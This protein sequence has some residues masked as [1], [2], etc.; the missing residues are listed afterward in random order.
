L[1]SGR[2]IS[3]T[4]ASPSPSALIINEFLAVNQNG[5]TDEDGD[6]SDWIEIYNRSDSA[7]NLAGWSLTTDPN[8]PQQWP[9]PD[10]TLDSEDYLI[11]FASGK[12]RRIVQ[13]GASLHTNFK[14]S[15]KGEYL[16]LYNILE[17]RMMDVISPRFPN[18]F[19]DI[20]YGRYSDDL[21]FG[22]LANP[23]PGGANDG[24]LAWIGSLAPVA[25]S[26]ERGLFNS[27]FS[28]ELTTAT[29]EATIRYTTDGSEPTATT[30]TI[31]TEPI[32]VESTTLLRTAAFKPNYL[33]SEV[34]T[35]SYIFVEDAIPQP[36]TSPDSSSAVEDLLASLQ[37][38]DPSLSVSMNDETTAE[39]V[40]QEVL[41]ASLKSILSISL[42]MKPQHLDDFSAAALKQ[43]KES[44]RPASV[45]LMVPDDNETGFQV[46]AGVRLYGISEAGGSNRKLA[47]QLSFKRKYGPTKLEYPLFPD[48]SLTTFDTL[49][50]QPR[51]SSN[52]AY[53]H[54]EWLR[55][56]QMA[57]SGLGVHSIPVHLYL[58]GQYWGLYNLIERPDA[59]FM[60]AYIGGE[61]TDWFVASQSGPLSGNLDDQANTLTYLFTTLA[62]AP[63]LGSE[64][65]QPDYLDQVY[66]AAGSYLDPAL[67]SDYMI[68]NLYTQSLDWPDSN[69]YAAIRLQDLA[70]RGRILVGDERQTLSQTQPSL[71][72]NNPDDT[73]RDQ[74]VKA[75]FKTLMENPD[76]RV[77]FADRLYTHLFK[78]GALIDAN[79]QARWQRLNSKIDEAIV[80]E[81]VRWGNRSE[82]QLT[83]DEWR[84]TVES[85]LDKMEGQA[86][87]F[88]S[89][90]REAG[91]YP[92]LDP[93]VF[94]QD[95]G[96]VETGFTM[97][98]DLPGGTCPDCKIYYTTDGSDP[99][100]AVTGAVMP[101]AM[102]YEA[103]LV[104]TNTTYIKAR[105]W[106]GNVPDEQTWSARHE[107]TFN[108]VE[109]DYQ[110][111][112][113]EIMYNPVGG[114]DYEFVELQN[115]GH[116]ELDLANVSLEE[117]IRFTFPPNAPPLAPGG[118]AVLV[119]NPASFAER[120]PD[121]EI[122]GA[123]E[124]HLS[125]KGEKI[126]LSN[127]EGQVLVEVEYDDDNGWPLSADGRGDSLILIDETGTPNDPK[128][129]R[130]S[131]NLNGSPGTAK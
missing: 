46:N 106:N 120:Y 20:A 35:R 47:L 113:T 61:Q 51:G 102:A 50:L 108:V 71:G 92:N 128:S 14:L 62:L 17:G 52:D 104:L 53:S 19:A 116:Q 126:I 49:V 32:R 111:R 125:N 118:M 36:S 48:S 43:G 29:P 40:S 75:W 13:P 117:G 27:P 129:W 59:N 69:W 45:E 54:N 16:A 18:Q 101:G 109:Q 78:D 64:L 60:S 83:Q 74:T 93:P 89:M 131:P 81:T 123:Y 84:Q 6:Y 4:S 5:L 28:V 85:E 97:T 105:T 124:G 26:V 7:V 9:F 91:Y 87:R 65:T 77:Q 58:N 112:L 119:S 107:A 76:F 79:A 66:A 68:L 39:A 25:F 88:I 38:I 100:L 21:G 114:D 90:M 63:Q 115:L 94:S 12:D 96:L 24:T 22:Y 130:A 72:F 55:A 23:T 122:R 121:V 3:A 34:S 95:G 31:Y 15:K 10:I 67:F 30:G 127:A 1:L 8:Q 33:P 82:S 98:M 11:V 2:H 41:A 73:A 110:L 56:S 86:D 99:R 57:M 70:S 44:E 37:G 103:P 80:A 42:V